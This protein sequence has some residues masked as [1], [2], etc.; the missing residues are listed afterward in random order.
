MTDKFLK[1]VKRTADACNM[2]PGARKVLAAVSGGPDS[3]AMLYGLCGLAEVYGFTVAVA[4]VDHG[5]RPESAEEAVFVREMAVRLGL[6]FRFIEARLGER[7]A[8]L[9]VNRQDESRKVRY[10]FLERTA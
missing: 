6:D 1:K 8:G 2:L 10:A 3:V 7:L 5:F 9:P 4:H